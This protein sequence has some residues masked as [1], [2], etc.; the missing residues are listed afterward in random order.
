MPAVLH[1]PPID[2]DQIVSIPILD[3]KANGEFISFLGLPAGEEHFAI[4]LG[5]PLQDRA[6]VRVHSE[7]LT[8]DVFD[9][10]R[11]DCGKQLDEAMRLMVREGG[12]LIYLRQEGRGIGLYAKLRTYALQDRGRDTYQA[13]T[14]LGHPADG[15]DFGVA[16]HML[17]ALG[18]R[19]LTLLT[20]NPD[21]EHA[22]RLAGLEV[23]P[24]R[25]SAF[26]TSHNGRYLRAKRDKAGH[27]L[28]L[29]DYAK[30]AP[31]RPD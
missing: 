19:S 4:R 16:A 20:N 26:E 15:R 5:R 8:G 13:N 18:V 25:T 24:R 28:D 7:C 30:E 11:C 3:G 17:K 29:T 6:L 21:K 10:Q 2:I 27:R 31:R 23:S 22:L 1:K 12:Y 9:S 14:D